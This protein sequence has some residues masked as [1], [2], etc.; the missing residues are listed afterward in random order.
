MLKDLSFCDHV[1]AI[2]IRKQ[3]SLC[4]WQTFTIK[5]GN[6]I[7]V[8]TVMARQMFPIELA[9]SMTVHKAQG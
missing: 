9:F 1:I 3:P 8:A 5:K 2:P 6:M 4:K 7:D